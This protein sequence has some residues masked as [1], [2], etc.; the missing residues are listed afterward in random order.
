MEVRNSKRCVEISGEC[1]VDVRASE[2]SVKVRASEHYVDVR[3]SDLFG[4]YCW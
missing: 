2:C 1:C 3:A 4:G